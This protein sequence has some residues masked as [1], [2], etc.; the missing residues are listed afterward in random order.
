[1]TAENIPLQIHLTECTGNVQ[2]LVLDFFCL[3]ICFLRHLGYCFLFLFHALS[4]SDAICLTNYL[5]SPSLS[6]MIFPFPVMFFLTLLHFVLDISSCT[7]HIP[8]SMLYGNECFYS[9][10][11][12]ES[13]LW[14]ACIRYSCAL[15]KKKIKGKFCA[16][17]P[18]W[19]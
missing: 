5:A 1:M 19:N 6:R 11:P 7:F 17:F 4:H 15:T 13:K 10:L 9:A 16:S 8:V 3:N 2:T 18:G 14:S 12:P